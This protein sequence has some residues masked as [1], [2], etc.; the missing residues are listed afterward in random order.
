MTTGKCVHGE[1]SLRE[2]CPQCIAEAEERDGLFRQIEQKQKEDT[3]PPETTN[4]VRVRYRSESTGAVGLREYTYFASEPLNVGDHVMVPVRDRMAKA[5]VS[6]VNVP[7]AEI[8]AY[9][10]MVKTISP[11]LTIDELGDAMS[12]MHEAA[13]VSTVFEP[14]PVPEKLNIPTVA[15]IN[16]HPDQDEA[17]QKIVAEAKDVLAYA[18][19]LVISDDV[20]LKRATEDMAALKGIREKFDS[21]E[22]EYKRPIREHMEAVGGIFKRMVIPLDQANRLFKDK[23]SAYVNDHNAKAAE[24]RRIEEE[25][26]ALAQR[27]AALNDG[28]I[29]VPLN[30]VPD[31]QEAPRLVR[32]GAGTAGMRTTWRARVID[33]AA[34][35]DAY[36]L[37]NQSVLDAAARTTKGP[38]NIKGVEFYPETDVSIRRRGA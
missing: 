15:I 35:D 14:I 30:T 22:K 29:T 21:K 7:G 6:S 8:E 34:L 38:S 16:V 13:Q 2:G 19:A 11:P 10:D 24:A 3:V 23:Y 36:K 31:I 27:E 18:E 5:I 4:I 12:I 37:A 33:F 28:E 26:L 20:G 9:R 25:K 1:F 17:I 32:T